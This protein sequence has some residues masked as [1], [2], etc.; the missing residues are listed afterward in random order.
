M[1]SRGSRGRAVCGRT[2][3]SSRVG[4][5]RWRRCCKERL[6]GI[7][8]EGLDAAERWFVDAPPAKTTFYAPGPES[9]TPGSACLGCEP[10]SRYVTCQDPGLAAIVAEWLHGVYIVP[11]AARGLAQRILL[12][13]GT[14]LVTRD[15][16]V[17]TRY[18]V[19]FHAPDTELHGVLTRQREI[20]ELTVSIEAARTDS[21]GLRDAARAVEG[22]IER[23]RAGVDALRERID[24]EQQRQHAL[25]LEA[26]RMR[27][28]DERVALRMQQIG[29]ELAEVEAQAADAQARCDS[30]ART[31]RAP[32][33]G[34][35]PRARPA[36]AFGG[37]LPGRGNRAG[38]P[39]GG[40]PGSP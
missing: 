17:F 35:P 4:R 9:A 7:A 23:R 1:H 18:S 24:A 31:H 25:Q 33:R 32:G 11:D 34:T 29:A 19:S 16:H 37:P 14:L 30:A 26:L 8:L 21:S 28:E 22:D 39:A 27:S 36:R 2:Y 6:N 10:L 13:A 20:E 38:A 12:P 40:R 15:G 3:V 5:T